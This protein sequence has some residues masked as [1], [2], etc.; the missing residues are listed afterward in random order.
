MVKTLLSNAGSM[1]LILVQGA[2]IPHTSK[3]KTPKYK[4]EAIL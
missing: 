4:T 3:A 2:K 1:G